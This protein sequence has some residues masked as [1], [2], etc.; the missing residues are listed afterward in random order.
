MCPCRF[1]NCNK[2]VSLEGDVDNVHGLGMLKMCEGWEAGFH[3][4]WE[5][6]VSFSQFFCT[7]K[8]NL[9]KLSDFFLSHRH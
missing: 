6:C 2:Y 7:L 4:T 9:E 3:N 8:S 1:I 5:I